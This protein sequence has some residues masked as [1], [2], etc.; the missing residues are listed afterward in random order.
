MKRVQEPWKNNAAPTRIYCFYPNVLICF[1]IYPICCQLKSLFSTTRQ[2]TGHFYLFSAIYSSSSVFL[3]SRRRVSERER[4]IYL[5]MPLSRA[6]HFGPIVCYTRL[7]FLS[8]SLDISLLLSIPIFCHSRD[9]SRLSRKKQHTHTHTVQEA[10]PL[11]SPFFVDKKEI[12]RF[13]YACELSRLSGAKK[14][15]EWLHQ[16]NF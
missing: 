15:Q 13:T 3:C 11:F 7:L 12:I 14:Q 10:H 6:V 16:K 2:K 1:V 9:L 4:D 5:P 8:R